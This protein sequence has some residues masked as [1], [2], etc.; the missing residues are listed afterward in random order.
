MSD[1]DSIL[2]LM[3]DIRSEIL[4]E[5][6][7]RESIDQPAVEQLLD[8]LTPLPGENLATYRARVINGLDVWIK[9]K[10]PCDDIIDIFQSLHQKP[11]ADSR[12]VAR[13]LYHRYINRYDDV[14][15]RDE[16]KEAWDDTFAA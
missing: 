15:E 13:Q 8:V 9:Q 3:H 14:D 5:A 16:I 12:L 7:E 10:D 6:L 11:S 1:W 2:V 4:T